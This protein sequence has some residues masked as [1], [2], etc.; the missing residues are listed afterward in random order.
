MEPQPNDFTFDQSFLDVPQTGSNLP[1]LTP[2]SENLQNALPFEY[3]PTTNDL[4]HDSNSYLNHPAEAAAMELFASMFRDSFLRPGDLNDHFMDQLMVR[5]SQMSREE[6]QTFSGRF[7]QRALFILHRLQLQSPLQPH[8]HPR[9]PLQ[10][11]RL[12]NQ[13]SFPG[14]IEPTNH[15]DQFPFDDPANFNSIIRSI[16][17]DDLW[18]TYFPVPQDMLPIESQAPQHSAHWLDPQPD[19]FNTQFWEYQIGALDNGVGMSPGYSI[20]ASNLMG[21]GAVP[22]SHQPALLP[23]RIAPQ[24]VRT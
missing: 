4:Y 10:V 22:I 21:V 19:I 24:S 12:Q 15:I 3:L 11:Q 1:P 14:S 17:L 23:Q 16:E 6:L 9:F 20:Y 8:V 13:E 18:L 2:P 7:R 5:A